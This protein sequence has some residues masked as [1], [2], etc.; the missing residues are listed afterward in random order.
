[1]ILFEP[2]SAPPDGLERPTG[3]F[4]RSPVSMIEDTICFLHVTMRNQQRAK[5]HYPRSPVCNLILAA[6]VLCRH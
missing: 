3:S 1:M 6:S 2:V 5:S 4:T